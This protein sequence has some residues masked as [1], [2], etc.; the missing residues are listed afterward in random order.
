MEE[1]VEKKD[2]KKTILLFITGILIVVAILCGWLLGRKYFELEEQ[3]EEKNKN[4]NTSSNENQKKEANL[5]I[6][7]ACD[8][9]SCV[10]LIGAMHFVKPDLA[11]LT[12]K[13]WEV[14]KDS[15]ILAVEIDNTVV[16]P[17]IQKKQEEMLLSKDGKDLDTYFTP[18]QLQKIEKFL[19]PYQVTMDK[20]KNL[21]VMGLHNNIQTLLY[22]G[23]VAGTD[24]QLL[25]KAKK[26]N[27]EIV[28]LE[29]IEMQM[30]LLY[31]GTSEEYAEAV[32]TVID[33]FE[34]EK[35]NLNTMYEAYRTGNMEELGKI[36]FS[37]DEEVNKV[38][39][40]DRNIAMTD[41]IEIFL[42]ENK[43][44]L[45]TVGAG[46]IIGDK[47]INRLLEQKGYKVS[48]VK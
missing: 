41:K 21:T 34:N 40:Y 15:D 37:D 1:K 18:E 23:Y 24:S 46:H 20:A 26:D 30:N 25:M 5:A 3:L 16:T 48:L 32:M 29:T 45:V 12:D 11:N 14:Y 2:T 31:N 17:E 22:T 39:F 19:K 35:K 42:K 4:T 9:D 10:Y 13:V 8:E 38:M 47:G 6:Y 27:K 28:E 43:K 36:A 33:N 44:V 7:Q